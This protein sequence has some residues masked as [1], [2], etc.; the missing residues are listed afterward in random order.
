MELHHKH[1]ATEV[2][3]YA[4]ATALA[5]VM[6]YYERQVTTLCAAMALVPQSP[7]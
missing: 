6:D 1:R 2:S 5:G 4:Q 7:C 3:S